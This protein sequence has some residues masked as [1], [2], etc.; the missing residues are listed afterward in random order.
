MDEL[1]AL[2]YLDAVVKE[3]LRVHPPIGDTVR[4]AM[5]DDI[6]PLEKPLTDMHGAVHNGIRQVI[7]RLAIN[8]IYIVVNRISKG[9]VIFIPILVMN[10]SKEL[11]E[12]WD[13]LPKAVSDIPGVWG[14]MLSFLGGPKACIAYR[15]AII[16]MKALVFT[17]VRA[18]EF[19][20]AVP[21]NRIGKKPAPLQHPILRGDPTKKPQLPL[22]VK[23]YRRRD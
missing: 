18:F 11:P 2:P 10:R 3:T 23:A 22:L 21:A 13:D 12:R 8:L 6:L 14:H 15:F 4:V 9:A 5:K 17:L 20:P 7:S 19:E 1:S 16:E